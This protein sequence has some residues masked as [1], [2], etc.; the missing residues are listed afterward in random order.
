MIPDKTGRVTNEATV[1]VQGTDSRATCCIG[2]IQDSQRALSH[3]ET[4][5]D[6]PQGR[7]S[8][9]LRFAPIRCKGLKLQEL[10]SSIQPQVFKSSNGKPWKPWNGYP[11][12]ILEKAREYTNTKKQAQELESIETFLYFSVVGRIP[13]STV[14]SLGRAWYT[15]RDKKL[16]SG[17]W[18]EVKPYI[19]FKKHGELS[20]E[21]TVYMLNPRYRTDIVRSA[22]EYGHYAGYGRLKARCRVKPKDKAEVYGSISQKLKTALQNGTGLKPRLEL[23]SHIMTDPEAF[24]NLP[25]SPQNPRLLYERAVT[26]WR[27]LAPQIPGEE[28]IPNWN[29]RP[30]KW[31]YSSKPSIQ[32]LPAEIRLNALEGTEGE[33]LTEWD[34]SG[35]QLNIS[36]YEGGESFYED[37][38]QIPLNHLRQYEQ[39]K[40]IDR[41]T[42]KS[43]TIPILHG[44]TRAQYQWLFQKGHISYP[45]QV[46]DRISE[47]LYALRGIPLMKIQGEIMLRALELLTED[48][49]PPGLPVF[50]SIL[51]PFPERVESAMNRA[52][53]E[54]LNSKDPLPMK[55]IYSGQLSLNFG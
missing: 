6:Y 53:M 49:T 36:Q 25:G 20:G 29:L 14:Y 30:C 9:S 43:L 50:D 42:V 7:Q 54:I 13:R 34:Y 35:V 37:P 52:A 5:R 38:Y 24:I 17:E 12:L 31:L 32:H 27:K 48:G 46:Y 8:E 47:V 26:A 28:L 40:D 45:V 4:K 10:N 55:A 51:S 18:I 1:K 41:E 11:R 2:E 39:F 19:R 44:R 23:I 16:Q 22:E 15:I 21:A 33:S 3:T